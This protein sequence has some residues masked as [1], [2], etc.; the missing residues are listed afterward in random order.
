MA[1]L[2]KIQIGGIQLYGA[3][4]NSVSHSIIITG[5]QSHS[6]NPSL[7]R[8]DHTSSPKDFTT[9]NKVVDGNTDLRQRT[10]LHQRL[11]ANSSLE[12]SSQVMKNI[13]NV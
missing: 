9:Q 5:L 12:K 11:V 7:A 6:L 3:R 13:I 8:F 1:Q 10:D 4:W 2:N